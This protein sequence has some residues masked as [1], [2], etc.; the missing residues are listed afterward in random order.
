MVIDHD[1]KTG[2]V[3]GLLCGLCNRG[4]GYFHDNPSTLR[5]AALYLERESARVDRPLYPRA[6]RRFGRQKA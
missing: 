3:R 5:Q 6:E 2:R 4:L 1:H